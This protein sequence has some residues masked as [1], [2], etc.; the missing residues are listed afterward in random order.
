[1]TFTECCNYFQD[2]SICELSKFVVDFETT[3]VSAV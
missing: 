3:Q 1:M 2:S